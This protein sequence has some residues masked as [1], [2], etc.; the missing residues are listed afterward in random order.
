MSF[1][2]P[3]NYRFLPESLST[4]SQASLELG[5]G[6]AEASHTRVRWPMLFLG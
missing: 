1:C 4:C 3:A 6:V 2:P 5:N